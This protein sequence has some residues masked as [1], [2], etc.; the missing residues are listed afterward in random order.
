MISKVE[1]GPGTQQ[2]AA[3]SGAAELAHLIRCMPLKDVLNITAVML[4]ERQ[5]LDGMMMQQFQRK[6]NDMVWPLVSTDHDDD[7]HKRSMRDG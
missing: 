3:S 2:A 4:A 7:L 6:I 5:D 1:Y